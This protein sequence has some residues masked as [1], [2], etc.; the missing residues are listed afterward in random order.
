LND[1]EPDFIESLGPAFTA[2][3]LR[4]ISDELVQ[5]DKLWHAQ[6]GIANPPRASSTLLALDQKEPLSM[7]EI[8]TLLR[9]SHQLIQQWV[10]ELEK[11]GLA[12]ISPDPADR[13]RSIIALTALGKEQAAELRE[14]IAPAERATLALLEEVSPDLYASLWAL[15]HRLRDQPMIGRIRA[16]AQSL[17][18]KK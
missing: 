1:E 9:Q 12:E 7:T 13:R 17:P 4:R 11:K 5:A 16:S 6:Q 10:R 18:V 15:E 8:A 14:A 3:L 2:H